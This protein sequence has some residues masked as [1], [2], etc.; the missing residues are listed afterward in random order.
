MTAEKSAPEGARFVALLLPE[1]QKLLD[2]RAYYG[3]MLGGL[4]DA[5][6]EKNWHMRPIQCMHEYQKEHFLHTPPGFY[7]GVVFMG[8]LFK[9]PLFVQA[10]VEKL[11]CPKV[12]L[13][14]HFENI[15]MHSVRED[16]VAGMR[17]V[18]EHLL[19][20]GHKHVAYLDND[21]PGA[22]PWKRE[23]VNL[24]LRE[25]GLGELARGWVA[26]CRCNFLDVAEALDW[27]MGLE[28]RPT[29]I[30]TC[31]DVRALL[32]L[33]AAA[34]R[35]MQVPRDLSITGYGDLAVRSGRSKALTSVAVDPVLMG[36]RAAELVAGDA[37]AAPVSVL[38]PPEL[39]VRGTAAAPQ[40]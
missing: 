39:L 28:P 4:S 19:A 3:P 13:D 34:E 29:A 16:A 7:R 18:T 20:L 32:L 9:S 23:G 8:M 40:T 33:Q 2:D 14:H 27:F 38:V 10:V 15:P 26:G 37:D 36:R 12:V 31:G 21:S 1:T 5:L 17:V 30:V 22:N 35:G 25:A 6:L 24:A 11:E